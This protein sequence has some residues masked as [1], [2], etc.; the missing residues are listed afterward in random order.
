M[1]V[2]S[3]TACSS[4]DRATLI[5]VGALAATL[6]TIC[7][8]TLGHGLGCIGVGGHVT[9]LASFWFRCSK[10]APITDAGGPLGNLVAGSL[11]I[12]L[13]SHV[14]PS[15]TGRLLLLLFG[16]LNLF[17]FTG[18]LTFES[19]THIHDDWY[20]ALQSHPAICRPVGAI[21]GIGGYVLVVEWLCATIRRQ[22]GIQAQAIRLAYA[23]AA[24]S[25]IIAGAMWRPEPL[26]TAVQGFLTLGIAPLGLLR[27]ARRTSRH[28]GYGI[29]AR[30]VSRSWI[31]ISACVLVFGV[32][33]FVQARG[34]GP[35][36]GSRLSP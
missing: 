15:P 32:F 33:L 27:V 21:V 18:Q 36:A 17:W 8:E 2:S 22:G 14:R 19:L 34:L 29:D 16:A 4:D 6:A 1:S 7:H 24:A 31:V 35:L 20:W 5:A 23:A 3:L 28:I 26:W 25:A 9:L 10:W 11:A 30:C 12:A 13:F